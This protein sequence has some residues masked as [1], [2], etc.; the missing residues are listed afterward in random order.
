M[1]TMI[2]R[3]ASDFNSRQRYSPEPP[4][5]D[6]QTK[7]GASSPSG[8]V[9]PCTGDR[10]LVSELLGEPGDLLIVVEAQPRGVPC[11]GC[12]C[13]QLQ[14]CRLLQPACHDHRTPYITLDQIGAVAPQQDRAAAVQLCRDCV[15]EGP[16]PDQPGPTEDRH[17][18]YDR[19]GVVQRADSLPDLTQRHARRPVQVDDGADVRPRSVDA[20]VDPELAVRPPVSLHDIAL[21]VEEEQSVWRREHGGG[22]RRDQEGVGAGRTA[23]DMSEG[24]HEAFAVGD[25]VGKCDVVPEHLHR[26]GEYRT[27]RPTGSIRVPTK[28]VSWRETQ[29]VARRCSRKPAGPSRRDS[30]TKY[31]SPR[32]EARQPTAGGRRWPTG[33]RGAPRTKTSETGWRWSTRSASFECWRASTPR[34]TSDASRRCSITPMGHPPSSSTES[35][36]SS[37]VTESWSTPRASG[38]ALRSVWGCRSRSV[39]GS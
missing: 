29:E 39:P 23:G 11:G 18:A 5:S 15:A 12:Q 24:S 37:P 13:L 34:R 2:R 17:P 31:A 8:V 26:G 27:I 21:T 33:S 14:A 6:V 25:P 36:A 30:P 32:C 20:G 35:P 38:G 28:S 1:P 9:V 3:R 19:P 10:D 7:L 4:W 22:A 16:A